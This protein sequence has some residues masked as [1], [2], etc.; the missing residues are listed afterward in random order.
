MQIIYI[1][2]K[3]LDTR[4]KSF[5]DYIDHF[6]PHEISPNSVGVAVSQMEKLTMGETL[7]QR[8]RVEE[9]GLRIVNSCC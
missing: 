3:A 1:Y 4:K 5:A 2:N 9:E 7:M 6:K 8:R